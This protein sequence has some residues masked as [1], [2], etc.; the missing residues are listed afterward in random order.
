MVGFRRCQRIFIL[1][2]NVPVERD[3]GIVERTWGVGVMEYGHVHGYFSAATGTD[4]G[5]EG[6]E[7]GVGVYD[8]VGDEEGAGGGTGRGEGWI[9]EVFAAETGEGC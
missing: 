5:G 4:V 9:R 2:V 3:R 1:W 6:A 8:F 7:T